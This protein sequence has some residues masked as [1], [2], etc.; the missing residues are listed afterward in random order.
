MAAE[1]TTKRERFLNYMHSM[2]ELFERQLSEQV[3]SL[4]WE[5]LKGYSDQDIMRA[6]NQAVK[7]CRFFPK[8]AELIECAQGNKSEQAILAWEK[9][10]KA[11]S[12]VGSYESVKFDDPAIH[13]CIE[14]MGGWPELCLIKPDEM[15]WKQKEFERLY[16]VMEKRNSH[17]DHLPGI[18]EQQNSVRGFDQPAQVKMIGEFGKVRELETVRRKAIA[19]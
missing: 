15:K 8:P 10:Y 4:Y 5:T 1:R 7:T 19:E 11:T 12:S 2:A 13:S 14:M 9:V 16:A 3:V 18:I 17:T 6:F